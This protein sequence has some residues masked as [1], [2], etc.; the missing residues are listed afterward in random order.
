MRDGTLSIY[1]LIPPPPPPPLS[2]FFFNLP[3]SSSC[4]Y[5]NLQILS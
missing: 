3:E 1:R 2:L 5:S 4:L